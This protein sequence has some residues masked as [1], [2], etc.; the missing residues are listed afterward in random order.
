MGDSAAY[1][2]GVRGVHTNGRHHAVV[3]MS[4]DV[5]MINEVGNE[6]EPSGVRDWTSSNPPRVNGLKKLATLTLS[7]SPLAKPQSWA[8]SKRA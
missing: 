8:V 6:C 7:Q 1:V 5:A 4:Q 2:F 3:L